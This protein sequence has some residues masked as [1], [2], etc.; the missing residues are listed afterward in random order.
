L[1]TVPSHEISRKILHLFS[2]IIP[3]GYL[4]IISEKETMILLLGSLGLVAILLEISR[5]KWSVVETIFEKYFNTMLRSEELDGGM[6]GATWMLFGSTITI[7]LFPKEIA[8]CAILFLC[9]GDSFAALIGQRFPYAKLGKKSGVGTLAGIISSVVLIGLLP[10]SLKPVVLIFSA[11]I[12]MG[13][14]LLPL[15]INDNLTI[16]ISGALA[17]QFG[18]TIL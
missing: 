1:S 3:L 11:T 8:I 4:W 17:L 16:P 6:T 12:S 10:L 9:I 15:P 5:K 13:I 2:A 7:F 14:E 18:A